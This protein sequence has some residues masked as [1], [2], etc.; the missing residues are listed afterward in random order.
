MLLRLLSHRLG[1]SELNLLVGIREFN[2]RFREKSLGNP[3]R[4]ATNVLVVTQGSALARA[5]LGW[6]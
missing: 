3:F 1:K 5:T 2:G 4:V 6:N